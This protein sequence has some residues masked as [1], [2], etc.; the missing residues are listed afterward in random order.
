MA[1]MKILARV[2]TDDVEGGY[3][4]TLE[5]D[6]GQVVRVFATENQLSDLADDIDEL[7]SDEDEDKTAKG[8]EE[9]TEEQPS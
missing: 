8:A 5:T 6:D 3:Q 1:P 7:L 9:T 2:L 4:I